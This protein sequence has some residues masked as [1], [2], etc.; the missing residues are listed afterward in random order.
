MYLPS[1]VTVSA[2]TTLPAVHVLKYIDADPKHIH[3]ISL[4]ED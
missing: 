4:Q 3:G 1:F 2:A